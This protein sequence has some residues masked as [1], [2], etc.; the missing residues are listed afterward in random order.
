MKS[1]AF[2]SVTTQAALMAAWRQVYANG[3]SSRSSRTSDEV[4]EYALKIDKEIRRLQRQLRSDKYVFQPAV[5]KK[6]PKRNPGDFRPLVIAPIETRII[7]R[8]VLDYLL[9]NAN[10]KPYASTPY[11]FGGVKKRDDE[12]LAAVPAAIRAALDAKAEGMEFVRCADIQSFFTRIRKSTVKKIV[13]D[14]VPDPDFLA[15]FDECIKVELSNLSE[16]G[17]GANRFPR[18]DLGVAQGSSLSPLMGNILLYDFDRTMNEGACRCIRYID[19][20]LILGPSEKEVSRTFRYAKKYLDGL[21]MDFSKEKSSFGV[22]NFKDGFVFLGIEMINGLIRPD[23]QSVG[24]FKE[25]IHSIVSDSSKQMLGS[26]EK[27]K[28]EF[29]LVPTMLRISG[30]VHGWGKHY[31]FCNDSNIFV[32]LDTHVDNEVRKLIGAYTDAR[33]RAVISGRRLLGV[34][35]LRDLPTEPFQWPKV[36]H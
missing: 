24:K 19:D 21:G 36:S 26:E 8:S 3:K 14:A 28:P 15:L 30:T 29:A 34:S 16:L 17:V 6:I 23:G 32:N 18:E 7:Q 25:K 35:S 4:D 2:K 10:L 22:Q 31:R 13:S 5:G 33:S 20:I 1:K 11:S 9:A 12:S 27:F